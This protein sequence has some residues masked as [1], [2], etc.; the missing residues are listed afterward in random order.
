[1]KT[2][3]ILEQIVKDENITAE[4][5][6]VEKEIATL[7]ETYGMTVEEVKNVVTEDML[8]NDIALKK[9][10]ALITDTVEEA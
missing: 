3:L 2:N 7:A 9:A 4:V 6:D 8:K 5:E 1:M 10:M